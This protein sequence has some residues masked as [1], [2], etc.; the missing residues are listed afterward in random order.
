MVRYNRDLITA[1]LMGF[2][3]G[4]TTGNTKVRFNTFGGMMTGNTGETNCHFAALRAAASLL[5]S[6]CCWRAPVRH[7]THDWTRISIASHA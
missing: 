5:F 3:S 4:Y 6:L 1:L 7:R 2:T